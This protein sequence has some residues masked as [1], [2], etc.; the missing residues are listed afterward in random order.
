MMTNW[1]S[2]ANQLSKQGSV[3][4][5][6]TL[7]GVSGSTPRNSGTKMVISQ[8]DIFDTIG[9]GHLEHKTIKHART[10]LAVGK[11]CQH[12]EHFQLGSNLGQC[13]GGNASVLFECFAA[14]GVNIM[15]FGAGHVGKALIPILAQLP[16]HVTWVDSREEQFPANIEMYPNVTKV[17]T[18]EPE[19]E[20]GSMPE[21]SYF[22]VM[23]HNHQMDFEISQAILKR[24]DFSYLGLIA[25]DTKW[26]RFKQRYKHRDVDQN[27]VARMSC[28]IGLEQ[29]GG[30]LPIE[31]A[32]SVSAE[33]INK[34]QAEE[35]NR[36]VEQVLEQRL[37]TGSPA[38]P[39]ARPS[40]QQGINW[41]E[42][43]Q[44]LNA[45]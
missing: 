19:F 11:N 17:V 14:V 45:D 42:L 29:V 13:C 37:D 43:K 26:R 28:P 38:A 5:L 1:S 39:R 31:V 27:Q 30:K 24:A 9:G 40:S 23:T 34:Y 3:Y 7:V 33:I 21:H 22:V 44:L 15:L 16:C 35:Q 10:M 41:K 4:V 20:V 36:Q 18:E 6:V 32:V 25:S 12:L 2:A 8:A